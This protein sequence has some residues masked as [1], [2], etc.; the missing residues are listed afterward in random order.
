MRSA[1]PT[2]G[3]RFSFSRALRSAA[4]KGA[5]GLRWA[6]SAISNEASRR[7]LDPK[8]QILPLSVGF[9]RVELRELEHWPWHEMRITALDKPLDDE[10]MTALLEFMDYALKLPRVCTGFVLTFDFRELPAM[11][12]ML[13]VDV[14]SRIICWSSEPGRQAQWNQRCLSWKVVAEGVC[15]QIARFL[16]TS[17]FYLCPPPCDVCLNTSPEGPPGEDAVHFLPDDGNTNALLDGLS[18]P[19]EQV[20]V[21]PTFIETPVLQR[22]PQE[23]QQ[24]A[25]VAEVSDLPLEDFISVGF[26]EVHQGF[27]EE[28]GL[29]YLKIL[30]RNGDITDSGLTEMMAFMDKFVFNSPNAAKGFSMTYDL[31]S[32]TTPSMKV[33]TRVAEWGAEPERQE[34][35]QRFNVACKVVV[36]E[37]LRYSLAKGVLCTFFYMCPPVCRTYL[38][39]DPDQ[40]DDTATVFE[41]AVSAIIVAP[42]APLAS[43]AAVAE[44]EQP[45]PTRLVDNQLASEFTQID[46]SGFL[47]EDH[48]EPVKDRTSWHEAE[49]ASFDWLLYAPL[50]F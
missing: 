30:G 24:P 36:S 29:G 45:L 1:A 5:W 4:P 13:H 11:S 35:W 25:L 22:R 44:A 46:E 8:R 23:Q 6:A 31:R 47:G 20:V 9:A 19:Q 34:T 40:P 38:L 43:S 12:L 42:A 26:C 39:W 32:L 28:S 14:V 16:L 48:A 3:E 10:G 33:V 21:K 27:D 49:D 7:L 2:R 18:S 15:F 41:P 50:G 17:T 37:G